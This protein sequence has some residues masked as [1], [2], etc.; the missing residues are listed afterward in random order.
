MAIPILVARGSENATA[1]D[2]P[3]Q[4]ALDEAAV[5]AALRV[6]AD[7]EHG[8]E[9][10]TLPSVRWFVLPGRDIDGLVS[11]A[12]VL[13]NEA[14]FYS[15]NPI[16]PTLGTRTKDVHVLKR[17]WFLVDV[18]AER[19][20][21]PHCASTDAEKAHA[22]EVIERI[23]NHLNE[24]GWPEPVR[25]DSGNGWHL[26]YR[27]DEPNDEATRDV[28]HACLK[29]LKADHE[30]PETDVDG[31]V[32]NAGR[33]AKLPGC[34]SKNKGPHDPDN[35]RPWRQCKLL[36]VPSEIEIVPRAYLE[37]LAA[38]TADLFPDAGKK[39]ESAPAPASGKPSIFLF[40]ATADEGPDVRAR[41]V[42]YL[43]A[44]EPA[45]SGSGGHNT[46]LS[47]ARAVVYGFDM[48][49]EA[50][51]D[52]LAAH[53]NPRCVP[54][55]SDRELR[56]KCSE[57]DKVAFDKPRGYLKD[58]PLP[59][60]NGQYRQ[61][62]TV[63]AKSGFG[64]GFIDSFALAGLDNKPMWLVQ[65]MFVSGQPVIIGGPRKT[66]KTSLAI[67]LAISL[68]S[69]TP[70]LGKFE[71]Y[72]RQRVAVFSGES[73][74]WTIRETAMRICASKGIS[75][76]ALGNMLLWQFSLPQLGVP[77]DLEAL[78]AGL[79][80]AGVN[81]LILEPLYLCL[82]AGIDADASNLYKIG[83]LL[84]AIAKMC[85]SIGVTPILCHHATKHSEV[86]QPLDLDKLAYS[87]I[88]EFAR[89]WLL[90][91]RRE[92]FVPGEPHKLILSGGGSCGQS[93]L[94][95]VDVDE[96]ELGEDFEGRTW[97]VSVG[98]FTE[99]KDA[100]AEAKIDAKD[101]VFDKR[102]KHDEVSLLTA[103][104]QLSSNGEAVAYSRV[105]DLAGIPKDRMG[106]A[107]ERLIV[108]GAVQRVE[109]EVS[110]GKAG[111]RTVVGMQKTDVETSSGFG[112]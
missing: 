91:S 75:L 105:R 66:L 25:I 103:L 31:A 56:H 1:S 112:F 65:R 18:D 73:G 12:K 67:D 101:A 82:L 110:R 72:Q 35:G 84:M 80:A 45:V 102:G 5:A 28:L 42:A 52:L 59:G 9:L 10:R 16:P 17:R 77:A 55:W 30:T 43:D 68:A 7:P 13:N 48:G 53:Y 99:A 19:P 69:G 70:F 111:T 41:A 81:V 85:A 64:C 37:A 74:D 40:V 87:G 38:G 96:G 46:T 92:E 107:F 36:S 51:F 50:G 97:D 83:P 79:K 62:T 63:D 33:I 21:K 78:R 4:F 106:Q 27:I 6:L 100:E 76:A 29:R 15:I 22:K 23:A 104:S 95:A 39:V 8:I 3:Q 34:W 14:V 11:A 2:Q 58:A 26:L 47:A 88:A 60:V 32:Y 71:V 94:W 109:V 49:P 108:A 24:L 61:E 54:P 57:A 44:M 90:I 89:Q 98:T 20:N 86:G 93:G